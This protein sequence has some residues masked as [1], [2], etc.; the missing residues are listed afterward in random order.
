MEVA[1]EVK[2]GDAQVDQEL[3]NCRAD[4]LRLKEA[5]AGI[6]SPAISQKL[7]RMEKCGTQILNAVAEKPER[8]DQV[9]KFMKY[10]LPTTTKLLEQYRTMANVTVKGEHITK[11]L[12]SVESS[13]DL[14]AGAFDK[15]LDKLYRDEAVDM[16]SDIQVLETMMA[17]DGLTHEGIQRAMKEDQQCQTSSN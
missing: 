13:L 15:Q 14:I 5:N 12:T 1:P 3:K 7:D 9:R 17:G 11:A 2:T 16:R 10:Y 8:A 6:P 4:L